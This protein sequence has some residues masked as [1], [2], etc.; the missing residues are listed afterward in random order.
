MFIYKTFLSILSCWEGGEEVPFLADV[1]RV[2]V[3][4]ISGSKAPPAA[5]RLVYTSIRQG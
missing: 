5:L 2:Y 1:M 3:E 4:G